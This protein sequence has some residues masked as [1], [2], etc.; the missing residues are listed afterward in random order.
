M[1]DDKIKVFYNKQNSGAATSR[2]HSLEKTLGRYIAFLD[3]DDLWLPGK[4]EQQLAF[5]QSNNIAMCYTSYE[6]VEAD[7]KYRNTVHVPKA[8]PITQ[9]F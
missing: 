5:M 2:N 7:G 1:T 9:V 4:L 6:T 3:A 8:R